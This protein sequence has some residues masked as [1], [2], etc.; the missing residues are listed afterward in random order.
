MAM[1]VILIDDEPSALE[2]LHILLDACQE[3]IN[4]CAHASGVLEGIKL[5]NKHKPDLIFIDIEMQDGTG[6]DLLEVFPE[7]AFIP[8]F[9]T[10]FNEYAIEAL[11]SGA[12]DYLLKPIDFEELQNCIKRIDHK[13]QHNHV[14]TC[15]SRHPKIR[16]PTSDGIFYVRYDEVIYL[17]GEGSY[18]R[19]FLTDDREVMTSRNIKYYEDSLPEPLF[20]RIHQSYVVNTNHVQQIIRTGGNHVVMSN[21]SQLEISRRKKD[22]FLAYMNSPSA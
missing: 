2:N 6:F 21:L 16:I 15:P 11:R 9:V 5:I 22:E 1:K 3:D 14:N 10:A 19:F 20:F 12:F 7:H 13:L 4:I 17:K 8:I 18:S